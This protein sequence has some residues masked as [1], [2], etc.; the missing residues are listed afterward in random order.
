[1]SGQPIFDDLGRFR[2]YR[3]VGRDIT[4]R[5][6]SEAELRMAHDLLEAKARELTRSN[7]ELQQ[8]AYVA[9]HDLQEP[10]RMISSY[11]Q[12][13]ERRYG[14]KLEGDAKD[15]MHFIVDGARA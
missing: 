1:V 11:T 14:D 4:R 10:L 12:L 15:F 5:R 8:F 13:L 7:E 2:G 9:S 6:T 3:G